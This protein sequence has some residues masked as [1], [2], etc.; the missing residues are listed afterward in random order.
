MTINN[1]ILTLIIPIYNTY[2]KLVRLLESIPLDARIQII[3]VDDHSDITEENREYIER[4]KSKRELLYVSTPKGKKGAGSARNVALPMALGEWLVFADSDDYYAKDSIDRFLED[5]MLVTGDVDIVF[6]RHICADDS[7]NED[8][9]N[10]ELSKY[11]DN[12]RITGDRKSELWLRCRYHVPW[13]RAIR[14]SMVVDNDF[15]FD[16]VRFANDVMF[17]IKTGLAARNILAFD[18]NLYV[19]VSNSGSLTKAK[20]ERS[21]I[22][23]EMVKNRHY[24]YW[25]RRVCKKDRE[26]FGWKKKHDF[27]MIK[28]FITLRLS[29]LKCKD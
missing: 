23:R 28:Q 26:L 3:I 1:F 2:D 6:C 20:D 9:G 27:I 10:N 4:E 13:G 18:Y 29:L 17:S 25:R 15:R 22:L 16:E 5:L 12:F 8:G 21:Q 14:R 24:F 11:V 7:L 19:Y